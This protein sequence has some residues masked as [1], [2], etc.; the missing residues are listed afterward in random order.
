M[1]N[2]IKDQD[3]LLI[4]AFFI[5]I[6]LFKIL[7]SLS[8]N[9]PVIIGD[10]IYY[11]S[12]AQNVLKGNLYA[13]FLPI[14]GTVPPGYSILIS[15]AYLF[16]N[17]KSIIYHIMLAINA[18]MT[19]S[20]IFPSYFILK[21]YCD[22]TITLLGS[23][24]ITTLPVFNLYTFTLMSENLFIPLFV[25]SIWFMLE[26][27]SGNNKSW[28]FLVAF[29]AV[30]LYITRSNGLAM[31]AGFLLAFFIYA[32]INREKSL[33]KLIKEKWFL[34]ATFV[35][36]IILWFS[37]T[38]FCVPTDKFSFGS[39]YNVKQSYLQQILNAP[40]NILKD[41]N[42]LYTYI[43]LFLSE[44]NY[45][46]L[47][48]YFF[49]VISLFL[50]YILLKDDLKKSPLLISYIYFIVSSIGL[51]FICLLFL[52]S[53]KGIYNSYGRYIEA[54]IP[55]A[56]IF[57]FI[58]LSKISQLSI[59]IKNMVILPIS[60]IILALIVILSIPAHMDIAGNISLV[61]MKSIDTAYHSI[62]ILLLS[63]ITSVLFFAVLKDKKYFLIMAI[64]FILLS[65][66]F[67][68]PAYQIESY[69]SNGN[70]YILSKFLVEN[71]DKNSK[72]LMDQDDFI[73]SG[74]KIWYLYAYNYDHSNLIIDKVDKNYNS[75]YSKDFDHI[76]SSKLLPY[77]PI[78]I[79][80]MVLGRYNLYDLKDIHDDSINYPYI[81]DIGYNDTGYIEGFSYAQDKKY[82]WTIDSSK[83]LFYYPVEDGDLNIT[84]VTGGYRPA[85]DPANVELLINGKKIGEF[86]KPAGDLNYTITVPA[87]YL[88]GN[89]HIIEIK[90]NTWRPFEHGLKED[91]RLKI[92]DRHLGIIIDQ[93]IINK[94]N[95]TSTASFNY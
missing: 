70:T 36:L 71:L 47:G 89:Y 86:I 69:E 2:R 67:T 44:V 88:S 15:I 16:S 43:R 85:N 77:K 33:Q 17:D 68:I 53:S 14:V 65:F 74:K 63:V 64:L 45:L 90:I 41:I 35:I 42:V 49:I 24:V 37:Y 61:Y 57:G 66:I 3:L 94:N 87:T 38:S 30:Y 62:F 60:V 21:K 19:T 95:I 54:I 39:P 46:I 55:V 27:Y 31:V 25:F 79:K 91:E 9:S 6:A 75:T 10:E 59:N 23:I 1:K 34:L 82:R 51:L 78:P 12:V 84:I 80:G 72:I 29:S 56:F 13:K 8:F 7:L 4:T 92:D 58:C 40:S 76:I 81:V 83:I 52:Y 22:R 93:L 48:S 20:V 28:D 26:S 5:L 73:T 11:D 50:S 18:L 32:W